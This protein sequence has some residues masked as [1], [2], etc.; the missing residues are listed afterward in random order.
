MALGEILDKVEAK[1]CRRLASAGFDEPRLAA[2]M[3]AAPLPF[4]ASA[5]GDVPLADYSSAARGNVLSSV[6]RRL[7]EPVKPLLSPDQ[8]AWA[9]LNL[10]LM[11]EEA[12]MAV[13][14]GNQPL[15]ER[16]L[17][18]AIS[19]VNDWYDNTNP[20]IQGISGTLTELADRNVDPRLPDISKSLDL[21]KERL[22]GRTAAGSNGGDES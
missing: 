1:G 12:E 3:E 15:Y 7:D 22:A 5:Y 21:L 18:K 10:Q 11:L 2:A 19:T 9:R 8:S 4:T 16:A 17:N 14:R 20:A 13:L 6:V